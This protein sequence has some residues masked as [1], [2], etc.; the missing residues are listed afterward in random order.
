MTD[1]ITPIKLHVSE[2]GYIVATFS[3]GHTIAWGSWKT[4]RGA[5]CIVAKAAKRLGLTKSKDG[6]SAS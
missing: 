1:Y 4:Q 5:K 3:D 6:L 2:K